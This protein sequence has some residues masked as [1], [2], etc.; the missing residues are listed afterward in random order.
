MYTSNF[1]LAVD[2]PAGTGYSYVTKQD[3]VR[4]LAEAAEQV[5]VF[6]SN[7]YKIFPEYITM[8]VSAS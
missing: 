6:L 5:V 4:E 8:D 7:L 1:W 2:Q 3:N